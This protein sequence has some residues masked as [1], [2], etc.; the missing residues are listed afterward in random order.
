MTFSIL[1]F[2]Q[3]TGTLG[4]AAATGSLCVGGWVLRGALNGGLVASQGTSPSTI[5][6]DNVLSAMQAG[7]SAKNAVVSV[8]Q[9]DIGKN[10]RQI[11]ALDR[12]GQ[13]GSFTGNA[14]VAW[15][16]DLAGDG[17]VCA[18]NM[19]VGEGV[20]KALA[21]AYLQSSGQMSDRLIS[22][23][24]AAHNSG[25]D[26]RGLLSAA[27]LVLSPDASPVDLRIDHDNDPITALSNLL[28][29]VRTRPYADWLEE[30]PVVNDQYRAPR[31]LIKNAIAD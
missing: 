12:N 4:G 21:D 28:Q 14:S 27:M 13:S 23:L 24:S 17:F 10:Q 6:R 19:I 15:A 29:S 8:I 26:S 31:N 7:E 20:L 2:D 11:I 3:K 18:G 25:G 22:A 30:V 5:W 9:P 1:A 16:G